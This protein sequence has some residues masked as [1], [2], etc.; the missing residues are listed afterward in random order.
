[1]NKENSNEIGEKLTRYILYETVD[2]EALIL[3]SVEN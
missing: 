2:F 3:K 1:V